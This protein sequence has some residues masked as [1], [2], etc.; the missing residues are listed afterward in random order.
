[1]DVVLWLDKKSEVLRMALTCI[2]MV[3]GGLVNR[4]SLPVDK[5]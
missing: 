5:I 1:M 4:A 3:K 2:I